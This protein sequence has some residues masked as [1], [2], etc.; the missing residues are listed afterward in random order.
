MSEHEHREGGLDEPESY[1]ASGE[2]G[3]E[4][5]AAGSAGVAD[6]AASSAVGSEPMAPLGD[7]VAPASSGHQTAPNMLPGRVRRG[8]GL[9]RFVVR[10]VATGGVVGIGVA[11]AA[12]L[13]ANTVQGWIIGLVVSG[14]S[15]V[16]S[17]ILWSSRQ[18]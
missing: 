11:I 18:L 7:G 17:A 6:P 3:S 12:I 4:D 15:V 14:V 2:P 5:A 8:T 10:V 16:L 13:A 1:R 9:E